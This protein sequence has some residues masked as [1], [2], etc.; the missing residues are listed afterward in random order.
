MEQPI[1]NGGGL[2]HY[3]VVLVQYE[4]LSEGHEHVAFVDTLDPDGG[5]T[6]WRAVE[7]INAIRDGERF[8]VSIG[9][10]ETGATLEPSICPVCPQVTL[11]YRS[12]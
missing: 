9:G 4:D 11:N 1:P 3:A 5:Q 10:T 6:R 7:L 12:S 8:V 2:P